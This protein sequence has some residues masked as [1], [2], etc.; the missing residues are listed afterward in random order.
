VVWGVRDF[1]ARFGRLP[2]G[3]WLAETA[4]DVE[5]LEALAKEGLRF[6][7][8]AP[9]QAKAVRRIGESSFTDVQRQSRRSDHAVSGVLP[10][11]RRIAVFF[12]DGQTS[13]AVAFERLLNHGDQAGRALL[14]G[15]HPGGDRPQRSWC[16]SPPMARPTD[17][18]TA[19]AR[20][21]WPLR[22]APSSRPTV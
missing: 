8:L 14:R 20:W 12:Y 21:R 9:H 15:F 4:V 16:T 10:S 2:E 6:T 5:T 19:M 17:I 1:A 22:C 7:I 11:G 18:T 13:R 3:M